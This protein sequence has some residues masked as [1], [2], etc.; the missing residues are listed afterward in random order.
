MSK[1]S[2]TT[3][4][5]YDGPWKEAIEEYFEEFFLFFFPNVHAD[6]DWSKGH[7]FLDKELQKIVRDSD[8]GRLY[9]DK[10]AQVYR[11]SGEET[12][13]MA[14]VDV[15][16]QHE[17]HFAKRMFTYNHNIADKYGRK[18]ATFAIYADES[19]TWQPN[20]YETAL[21]GTKVQFDFATA[22]LLDYDI[23]ELEASDNPFA[24]VVL[25]HLQTKATHNQADARYKIKFH[26]TK[27]LYKRGY[28]KQRILSLYRYIDWMMALPRDMEERLTA[29]ITEYEEVYKMTYVTNAERI[30]FQK[31]MERGIEDGLEQG[32]QATLRGLLNGVKMGLQ[33]KFGAKGLELLSEIRKINDVDTLYAIQEAIVDV[34][35]PSELRHVYQPIV[36]G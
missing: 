23:A 4:T 11:K 12:W 18:V 30:G 21:W 33:L 17:T 15:Q 8:S 3:L 24:I 34:E 25:A 32:Q 1:K 19:K 27:L 5:E 13:V 14:H 22:K 16:S 35:S 2:K 26:L 9:V 28:S 7:T 29:D 36:A 6:I 20:H 10:L 31:G